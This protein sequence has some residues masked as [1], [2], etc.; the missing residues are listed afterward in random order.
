MGW[1]KVC[2]LFSLKDE[3]SKRKYFAIM[4]TGFRVAAQCTDYSH[5]K[6][7]YKCFKGCHA[8]DQHYKIALLRCCYCPFL[9]EYPPFISAHIVRM[10]ERTR[11]R[12]AVRA[13]F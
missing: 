8:M 12:M 5:I 11:E 1:K 9:S 2:E 10:S 4:S 13:A 7:E 6:Y 3:T